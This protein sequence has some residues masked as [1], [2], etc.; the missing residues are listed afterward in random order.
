[1]NTGTPGESVTNMYQQSALPNLAPA[2]SFSPPAPHD[3]AT[4]TSSFRLSSTTPH[5]GENSPSHQQIGESLYAQSSPAPA[6]QPLGTP[7]QTS[8]QPRA[9]S[10]SSQ[11]AE[12]NGAG[13]PPVRPERPETPYVQF[14]A[15]M[16]PQLEADCYPPEQIPA[17]IQTEWDGLSAE[18]RKLWDD[19]Y[20]DQMREYTAAMDA[21]KR[22][23]RREASSGAFSSINS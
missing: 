18:N 10:I 13:R 20:Q 6:S 5:A 4:L 12:V 23:T 15:H 3:P 19:R 7:Y 17:R 16:R 11:G 2:N 8:A 22:A 1:M 21:Y 14:T 9:P